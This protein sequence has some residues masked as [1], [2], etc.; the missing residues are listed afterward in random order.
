MIESPEGV[1]R[2][3]FLYSKYKQSIT[4]FCVDR[5]EMYFDSKVHKSLT[6]RTK[7]IDDVINLVFPQNAGFIAEIAMPIVRKRWREINSFVRKYFEAEPLI[8]FT[9]VGGTPEDNAKNRSMLVNRNF[10][11]TN[12]RRDCFRWMIDSAARYGSYVTFTQYAEQTGQT[13][14]K[15]TIYDPNAL[16][17][18][19]RSYTQARKQ[20]A[21]TYPVHVL[22]Y[23]CDPEKTPYCKG[24]YEGIIDRWPISYLHSLLNDE[25]YI[26]ENILKI[27]EKC[28]EG[29]TDAH[30]YGGTGEGELKDYSR[31]N[32]DV[33]RMFSTLP[34]KGNEDDATE[35]AIEFIDNEIVKINESGLDDNE[36]P[37][38]TASL[39][40]RPNVWWGNS[41]VEDIIPHQ[42]ISNWLYNTSFEN[43]MKLMDSVTMYPRGA[44]DLA[45]WNNRHQ[46]GGLVP[47]DGNQKPSDMM[48]Q[49]QRKDTSLNNV[50]WMIREIKQSTQESSPIVN[51]QNKY[52][53]GGLNNSTLGAAQMV[54]SIG[55]I[56]QFDMMN[57]FQYGLL[58][59]GEVSANILEI[60]L[61]EQ[62][63]L[64]ANKQYKVM[65]KHQIMG[66]FD[67]I[68]ESSLTLNDQT[69][70]AN[71]TNR[72]TQMLN[73]AGTGRPEFNNINYSRLI[74]DVLKSGN[75]WYSN[76]DDYYQEQPQQQQPIGPA[77]M[78]P[79]QQSQPQQPQMAGA[80]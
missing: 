32:V 72:L 42:N 47:Y 31:E 1:D 25:N 57:N 58:H 37:I 48:H 78:Q 23:F 16:N 75:K 30:W 2:G 17:P 65:E 39:L 41:D 63:T 33:S 29:T 80:Q 70:F 24:S 10:V 74:K 38:S 64:P 62:F 5:K 35:Y 44:I 13:L 20:N 79:P 11:S 61:D 77:G 19:Q 73:W 21:R 49:F 22:N 26:R 7:I 27:I 71:Q 53:E 6:N 66:E 59:I 50:D 68:V 67:G 34:F 14:G 46:M 45:D 4:N 51:M 54:A 55:E 9:A 18:Y 8:T 36:R 15:K 28:K 69:Q 12:F 43:T 76:E 56:L 40:N 3:R 60:M 52:N